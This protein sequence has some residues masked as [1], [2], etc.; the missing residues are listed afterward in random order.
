[1]VEFFLQM[2]NFKSIIGETILEELEARCWSRTDFANILGLHLVDVDKIIVG[3]T[4]VTSEIANSLAVAT[5]T[6]VR[7][8]LNLA[9]VAESL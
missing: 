1:M 2:Q 3:H 9:S 8:W 4:K 5:G 7:F 6:S